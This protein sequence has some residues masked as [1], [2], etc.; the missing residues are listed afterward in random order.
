M[1]KKI[2]CICSSFLG[3]EIHQTIHDLGPNFYIAVIQLHHRK[4]RALELHIKLADEQTNRLICMDKVALLELCT[5]L[6]QF[7]KIDIS[8]PATSS[9]NLCVTVKQIENSGDYLINLNGVKFT[10]DRLAA[11]ELLSYEKSILKYIG[12][13]EYLF[14]RGGYDVPG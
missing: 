1:G 3:V 10:L 6:H 9:R 5:Q 12:D 7:E 4:P 14:A 11:K 13:V 2:E 8:Y